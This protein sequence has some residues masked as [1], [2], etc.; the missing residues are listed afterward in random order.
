MRTPLPIRVILLMLLFPVAV[1]AQDIRLD[2]NGNIIP[3][4]PVRSEPLL[5]QS[6]QPQMPSETI[7]PSVMEVSPLRPSAPSLNDYD[8]MMP[9][10]S[11]G[12]FSLSGTRSQ[13]VLPASLVM[14][15]A[16][17]YLRRSEGPVYMEAYVSANNYFTRSVSHQYGVGGS[18]TYDLSDFA[19]L[20]V[21][22]SYYNS[23]PYFTAAS[24]GLVSTSSYGAYVTLN[25]NGRVGVNLGVRRYYDPFWGRWETSPI[26]T[27]RVR[28][29]SKIQMEIPVG[30]MVKPWLQQ[31]ISGGRDQGPNMIPYKIH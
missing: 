21:F 29:S 6:V 13:T 9:G 31:I 30:E 5:K 18:L 23:N 22:G 1:S 2:E 14:Q 19:S 25:K 12:G 7:I 11:V 8:V 16:S 28:I 27:P 26:I 4:V 24:L 17:L 20:T 15:S 10:M 3:S